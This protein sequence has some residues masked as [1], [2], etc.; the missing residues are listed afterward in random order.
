MDSPLVEKAKL[1]NKRLREQKRYLQEDLPK[2]VSEVI[3]DADTGHRPE[4]ARMFAANIAPV[5]GIIG[6][7]KDWE[8]GM[9]TNPGD[10][11]FNPDNGYHFIYSGEPNYTHA[12]PTFYPG[13]QGVYYWQ[14]IPQVD[15]LTGIKIY[16]DLP[17]ITV[18]VRNGEKWYGPDMKL[19]QFIGANNDNCVWA[20]GTAPTLWKEMDE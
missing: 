6:N 7:R 12:N 13:A 1:V 5:Q 19:Y 3:T 15:L 10:V 8:P 16:P 20:P 18:S 2:M 11:V 17:G 9:T 14:I 4:K